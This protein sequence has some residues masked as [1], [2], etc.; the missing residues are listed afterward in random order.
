MCTRVL[1]LIL[2]CPQSHAQRLLQSL[3]TVVQKGGMATMT[4]PG[5]P[6]LTGPSTSNGP[7]LAFPTAWPLAADQVPF[8]SVPS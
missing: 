5:L 3:V 2:L 4:F 1:W 6:E 8:P 7:S